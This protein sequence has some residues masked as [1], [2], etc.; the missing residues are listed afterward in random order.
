MF[1]IRTPAQL[2]RLTTIR[3]CPLIRLTHLIM[4]FVLLVWEDF[5]FYWS[6]RFLHLSFIYRHV[7]KKHHEFYNPISISA[8]YAHWFEYIVLLF[9]YY[10]AEIVFQEKLHLATHMTYM[11]W[12]IVESSTTHSGYHFPIQPTDWLPFSSEIIS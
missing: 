7:H 12:K 6:H 1:F 9:T 10:G 4:F 8:P 3:H 5:T 2:C 11:I